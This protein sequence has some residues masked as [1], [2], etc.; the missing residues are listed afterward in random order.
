[1]FVE[2]FEEQEIK[3]AIWDCDSKKSPR[4]DNLHFHFL[5]TFSFWE[6]MKKD[7]VRFVVE[8]HSYGMLP[9]RSNA[10]F[11]ALVPKVDEPQS[12]GEFRTISLVE[13]MYKIL[14]KLLANRLKKVLHGVIDQSLSAFL[15]NRYILHSTLI[16]N[17]TIIKEA[18]KKRKEEEMPF[19]SK[20]IMKKTT[21]PSIGNSS[22]VCLGGWALVKDG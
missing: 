13:C 22:F 4:T 11:T 12:L 18:K 2:N 8:F 21:T 10:S 1:M 15:G 9:R 14:S 3:D 20:L 16:A 5:K 6:T 19:F 17:E 7:V